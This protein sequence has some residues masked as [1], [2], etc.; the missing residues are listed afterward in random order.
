MKIHFIFF[1]LLFFSV[2]H[3][4]NENESYCNLQNEN[5]LWKTQFEK[6]Y[7]KSEKIELIKAKIISDSIY[8]KYNP[9]VVTSH[10]KNVFNK[11][12]DEND[13]DCG[14]KIL[15]VLIYK[16][17]KF[18]VLDLNNTPKFSK[19]IRELNNNNI[20]EIEFSFDIGTSQSLYGD[21][22]KCGFIHLTTKNK[23]I[24]KA[25]KKLTLKLT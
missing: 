22:G 10:S 24:R 4:Q 12:V 23:E 13:N 11:Y 2:I 21:N 16:K 7:S 6:A 5:E 14:C 20:N 1:F 9:K 3:S 8:K 15:F 25:I 18:L 19:M 17:N